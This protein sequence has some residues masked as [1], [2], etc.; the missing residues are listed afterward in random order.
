[1]KTGKYILL[2]L[3]LFAI[4]WNVVA[5]DV[6]VFPQLGHFSHVDTV[7][8]SPDN[9]FI[10]SANIVGGGGAVKLWD[11]NTGREIRNITERYSGS[12]TFSPNGKFILI[13]NIQE[14]ILWEINTGSERWKINA[15]S[16]KQI[17][18]AQFCDNGRRIISKHQYDNVKIWDTDTGREIKTI[19]VRN[20][21][22]IIL[23][24]DGRKLITR[25]DNNLIK[26]WDTITGQEIRTISGFTDNIHVIEFNPDGNNVL[27]GLQEGTLKLLNIMTDRE[28]NEFVGHT[29]S[30]SSVVFNYDGRLL[31]SCSESNKVRTIKI[32]DVTNGKEIRTLTYTAKNSGTIVEFSPDGRQIVARIGQE[33]KIWDT[34]TGREI[35]TISWLD[36]PWMP[37][38]KYTQDGRQIIFHIG[39]DIKIINLSDGREI[40]TLTHNPHVGGNIITAFALS[41]D[42]KLIVSASDREMKIWDIATGRKISELTWYSNE[43]NF[44]SYHP[45]GKHVIGSHNGSLKLWNIFTG[46]EV[47]TFTNGL[48]GAPIAFSPDGKQVVSVEW[49]FTNIKIWETDTGKEIKIFTGHTHPVTSLAYSP[50]GRQIVS[51]AGGYEGDQ[52]IKLWDVNTGQ[53][54]INIAGHSKEIQSV[55]FSPDGRRIVS[56]SSDN[57]VKIWDA[58]TGREIRS[59]QLDSLMGGTYVSFDHSGR[60]IIS[61][62]THQKNVGDGIIVIYEASTGR[63]IWRIEN[64]IHDGL[65]RYYI[66][67]KLSPDG[68]YLLTN[69]INNEIKIFDINTRQEIKNFSSNNVGVIIDSDFSPDGK[70]IITG[71]MDGTIRIWDVDTCLE[72]AQ[73]ISF[74]DGEWIVLTPDGYYNASPNGDKYLNVRVGNNVYGIDQYRLT[75]YRPNIVEARL[76][77]KPDPVQVTATIQQAGEPPV[78]TIRSPVN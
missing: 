21:S 14:L 7:E 49:D 69:N 42:K 74:T 51:C 71:A 37:L 28:I 44:V 33:I 57:T 61:L 38:V 19:D 9:K 11:V 22:K 34:S 30:V 52:L 2:G 43:V 77:G 39:N 27:I 24:P 63:E 29:S 8:I 12:T 26:I 60:M 45:D 25:T 36:G 54:I 41:N 20:G 53:E 31:V 23:S 65:L 13:S 3:F 64:N 32:W 1:M 55:A 16:D 35:K 10:L 73:F 6:A 68:R 72:T 67:V 50:D 56:G 75:F 17:T 70:N 18:G 40:R 62:L 48:Y 46:R 78:V 47:R 66:N 4:C 59:I 5:Q 58:T 76:Q 15:N